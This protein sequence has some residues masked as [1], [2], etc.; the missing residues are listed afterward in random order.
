LPKN[1]DLEVIDRSG[2]EAWVFR[3]RT[4]LISKG[5]STKKDEK[6]DILKIS[7]R[8][9]DVVTENLRPQGCCVPS[10]LN[11]LRHKRQ[12]P[13]RGKVRPTDSPQ[14]KPSLKGTQN[15]PLVPQEKKKWVSKC[16]TS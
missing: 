11:E 4:L 10:S 7:I 12:K 3:G 14:P 1:R 6:K 15:V 2:D 8:T 9:S 5:P 13:S 16:L